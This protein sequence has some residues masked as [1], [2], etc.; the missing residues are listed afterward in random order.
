MSGI[1]LARSSERLPAACTTVVELAD[2]AGEARLLR[3]QLGQRIDP[4]LVGGMSA[5][6]ARQ[7]ALAL[8]RFEDSD[9]QL[10]GGALPDYVSLLSLLGIL[11][12]DRELLADRWRSSAGDISL[13][14]RFALSEDGPLEVDLV[15]DGPHG[16]VAGTTGAGKSELLRRWSPGSPPRYSPTRST[17]SSSTTRAAARSRNAPGCRTPSGMVT[18][19]DE[20][21]GERAL[22]SLEAELRYRERVLREHRRL[23]PAW[24][25]RPAG[26]SRARPGA[27]S[28]CRGCVVVID[29]FATLAAELPDFVAV[30]GRHRPAR[31]QPR[32][33]PGAGHP[34]PVRCRERE[35]PRQ[36]QPA[37]LPA[38]ADAA[39]LGR[40]DRLAGRR[41]DP[42]SP[43]R[44]GAGAARPLGA[45]P[46]ADRAGDRRHRG[47]RGGG[48]G[49]GPVRPRRGP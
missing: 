24:S 29:E 46:G 7:C 11:E 5:A 22:R 28:R 49:D 20:Q 36:H 9:L 31:S 4:L 15:A 40:R 3:P 27:S 45:A 48:G 21:L 2:G 39:G 43:A 1:V 13:V 12:P 17:S 6:T 16:L 41:Q 42:A 10:L 35:H 26:A 34:A 23:G 18:D 8:A 38:G 33:A 44:P 19:L 37:H 32:R 47:R 25:R 30:A 14:T